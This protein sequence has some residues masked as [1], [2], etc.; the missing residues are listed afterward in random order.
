MHAF[1]STLPLFLAVAFFLAPQIQLMAKII[2]A[3]STSYSDVDNAVATASPGDTVM[4]PAGTSTWTQQLYSHAVSLIG[5]GSNAT[6]I[7]DEIPRPNGTGTPIFN[8]SSTN[9]LTEVSQLQLAG[10]VTNTQYN[11]NGEIAISGDSPESWRIDHVFFNGL[12]GKNIVAY[13]NPYAVIDH[14]LFTMRAVSVTVY[15]DGYGDTNWATPP[16]YGGTDRVYVES[17]LFTN[18]V[19]YPAAVM[20]GDAGARVV[21]RYNVVLNDFWANHGTESGQRYRSMRSFEIYNNSFTDVNNF[22]WAIQLRGGTGAIYNNT[23]VG[24][25]NLCGMFYYRVGE[26]FNPWGGANGANLWDTNTGVVYLTGTH[27]GP[28][29]STV[30]IVNNAT[31]TVNQWV[32]Y[33]VTDTNSGQFSIITSNNAN[34]ITVYPSKDFGPM[35]FNTGDHFTISHLQGGLDQPGRGSGD[36]LSGNGYPYGPMSNVA[37][38]GTNW[39]RQVSEPVYF[40]NNTLNGATAGGESDYPNIQSGRDYINNTT[41]PNYTPLTYPHPLTF[42]TSTSGGG[43]GGTTNPV[44]TNPVTTNPVTTTNPATTNPVTGTTNLA[45]PSNLHIIPQ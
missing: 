42:V 28:S 30:L 17:C 7:I 10:G 38:G 6:I 5:A 4:I 19:G 25:H 29:G 12:Y 45:P 35:T 2:N 40:W 16:N 23:A 41:K 11:Y 43:G 44:T 24:Y 1:R 18:I 3:A 37:I 13:G 21:F 14:C 31:W 32:G 26:A 34:T 20:D 9:Q 36:L 8:I 27:S 22:T 15:A 39:P 33:S